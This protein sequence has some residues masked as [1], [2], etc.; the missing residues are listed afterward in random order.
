MASFTQKMLLNWAGPQKY[1]EGAVLFEKN[2][3]T[4]LEYEPPHVRGLVSFGTRQLRSAFRILPDGS[5]ESRC[6]CYD[7]TERGIVCAHVVALGL[8]LLRRLNDPEQAARAW[9]EKR[10]AERLARVA[11]GAYLRRSPR[12]R[13]GRVR[14]E[15]DAGWE[16]GFESGRIPMR[17]RL[18]TEGRLVAP[19]TAPRDAAWAFPDADEAL[20]FVWEDICEGPARGEQT[21]GAS[22]FINLLQLH[23][24]RPLPRADG[25]PAVRVS[26]ERVATRLTMEMDRSTGELLLRLRC[27]LP[28]AGEPPHFLIVRRQGWVFAAGVFR[29]LESLLPE[30]LRDIYHRPVVIP[31]VAVPG[32][33]KQEWAALTRLVPTETDLS[34]DLF[35]FDPA[36]PTF[37]LVV[38]GSPASL[39]AVLYADYGATELIVGRPEPNGGFAQPDP[40]DLLRYLVRH[41]EREAAALAHLA[42]L[43][44]RGSA[45]DALEPVV[46]CRE[47]N[48]FLASHFPA[49]RR[50][51]WRVELRG[52]VEQFME[53][54]AFVTPVVRV[55]APA[56]AAGWFEVDFDFEDQQ[57]ARI[58]PAD[59]QRAILKGQSF[60]E[61]G[62]KTIFFDTDAVESLRGVFEDCATADGGRPGSFRLAPVYAAYVNS[63]LDALDGVD[64]EADPAWRQI[65]AQ[66]TGAVRVEPAPLAPEVENV[67][68]P[69]Q[70]EGVNWLRFL[71]R[72]AFGGIL[73]DE[74]GLGKTL[75]MLVWLALERA[76]PDARGKPALIVC[77]TSLVYNWAEEAQRFMPGLKLAVNSGADRHARWGDLANADVIVTSYA[78]LRRD[79]ERFCAQ[80]YSALV[81]DEAQHI[82]NH[83]TQ[84]AL[85]AKRIAAQNRFVLTGTPMENSVTDLWS[86][87]DFLMPGYLGPYEAF[88]RRYEQPIAQDGE[89]GLAAQARLRRKLKPF[90]LRRLKRDVAKE[91]PPKIE[92]VAWCGLTPDQA[93]VYRQTLEFSRRHIADL[94]AQQGV[95]ASRMEVLK[96]LLRLRQVCCHLDLLKLPDLNSAAP[97]AKLDLFFELLD[98]ALDGGHRV[99]VFSQFVSMLT[100]L[101]GALEQRGLRY[102][103]LDGSTK[104]R[105]E[106]V[107]TFN[108][109][110]EI[111]VFL[112]SLKAGGTGLNLTGADTVIH[113][114]PWWNPAVEDQA[115]DRAYRIGQQRTVYSIKLLTRDT[116]EEKVLALQRRKQ[117]LISATV[118]A[119]EDVVG[120]MSWEDIRELLDL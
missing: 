33:L 7:N 105:M 2:L 91:L 112:I 108:R 59:I 70:R 81:L 35:R 118:T 14:L 6:P 3:V 56:A 67:L 117:A 40:D 9:E 84:N 19:E 95:S 18:E 72:G 96:T 104:D 119:D 66:Q 13:P 31:R 25:A 110:R 73:A 107:R 12:G 94:V 71:E 58:S 42:R 109:E 87:M 27:D 16:A 82:K 45:G 74:M 39:S 93:E 32:F 100:I 4:G 85:A 29:P 115:T 62:G 86:I 106:A 30:P 120:K 20:L 61:R 22:D 64:V 21:V 28:G 5:V 44:F 23:Q 54:A 114:D 34:P 55:R 89:E 65:A 111:P 78:L 46:G 76:H 99:L 88:R 57:G 11:E 26:P 47:V 8:A 90:L 17:C 41:P 50:A 24:D 113:F 77:P 10:R 48:N 69:Y 36:T 97:S 52:R 80:T 83:S 79:V 75:Q 116:V 98:E 102:S 68:R 63:S 51:G 60:L 15:L 1:H 92:R 103:Y 49:L 38:R 101:R 43:G 37:R 53:E